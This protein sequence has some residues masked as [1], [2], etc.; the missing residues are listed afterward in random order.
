MLTF[1]S[2]TEISSRPVAFKVDM[3]LIPIFKKF[4]RHIFGIEKEPL[5]ISCSI[6]GSDSSEFD[7]IF[8][9]YAS[10]E[11]IKGI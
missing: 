4:Y 9:T 2:L 1:K 8:F 11:I 7:A 3:F 5:D 10:K 6:C